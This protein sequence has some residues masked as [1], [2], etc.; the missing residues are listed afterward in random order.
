[1]NQ[2]FR[3]VCLIPKSSHGTNPASAVLAGLDIVPV[4]SDALGNID[5]KDLK[6]KAEKHKAKLSSLMIT[7][8]STH[9][10]FEEKIKEYCE[11]VHFFGG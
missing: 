9:G 5:L 1:M 11:I 2:S 6:E 7:Y 10:V 8:P 4:N 3:N